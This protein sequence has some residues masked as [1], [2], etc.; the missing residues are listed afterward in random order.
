MDLPWLLATRSNVTNRFTTSLDRIYQARLRSDKVRAIAN[1]PTLP[2]LQHRYELLTNQ[3]GLVVP[4]GA[5]FIQE[6]SDVVRASRHLL[7]STP[8]FPPATP[9]G[10]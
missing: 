3:R 2:T 4:E 8:E 6:S 10:F 7:T 9:R 1:S 5:T